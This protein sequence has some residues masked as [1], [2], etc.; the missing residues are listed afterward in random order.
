MVKCV[1]KQSSYVVKPK[2]MHVHLRENGSVGR[3]CLWLNRYFR[4]VRTCEA[5]SSSSQS[6]R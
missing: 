3:N 6:P 5:S 2:C 1:P 4:Y